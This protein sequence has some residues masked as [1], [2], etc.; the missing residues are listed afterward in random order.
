MKKRIFA[1]LL[2]AVMLAA[3]LVGCGGSNAKK[4]PKNNSNSNAYDSEE[5][6]EI[7]EYVVGLSEDASYDGETFTYMGGWSDNFPAKEEETADILSN[8]LFYRQRDIEDLYG[9]KWVN[10]NVDGSDACKDTV[11]NEVMAG[12]DSYDLVN[13]FVRS[14]GRPTLNAGVLMEMQDLSCVDLDREWWNQHMWDSYALDGKLYFL[15]GPINIYNYLDTFVIMFNK[16]VTETFGIS[17]ADLYKSVLDGTWTIDRMFE[18]A[19]AVPENKTGNGTYRYLEP[20]GMAFLYGSGYRITLF[21]E[22]GKPYVPDKL[23]QEFSDLADKIT[24]VFTDKTQTVFA[25]SKK[26]ENVDKKYG[27]DTDEIFDS[28]Q[29]LFL[30][31]TSGAVES[32]RKYD[33]VFGILPMPKLTESQPDYYSATSSWSVGAVYAPKTVRNPEMTG[34]ITESMAALS[35]IYVREAYYEKLL[36]GQSIFDSESADMLDIIFSTKVYDMADLYCDGDLNN[37]GP[38]IDAIG[39]ALTYD[40]SNFSSAYFANAKIANLNIMILLRTLDEH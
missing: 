13:G 30:Y 7:K 22:D 12:G 11:I 38:F 16:N 9:V 3:A 29:G 14:V 18:V 40:N 4:R 36:K 15:L 27:M 8:A 23:P 25:D 2:V 19:S 32:M 10:H 39:R 37:L 34:R 20:E 33:V 1:L 6:R 31:S 35:Q 28:D 5:D 24:P 21:D 26:N 17:D